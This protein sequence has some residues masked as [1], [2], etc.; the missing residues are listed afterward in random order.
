MRCKFQELYFLTSHKPGVHRTALMEKLAK[1]VPHLGNLFTNHDQYL[2]TVLCRTICFRPWKSQSPSISL[3][4]SLSSKL[5]C[6][7]QNMRCLCGKQHKCTISGVEDQG[8]I[9]TSSESLR[10]RSQVPKRVR[11]E[12]QQALHVRSSPS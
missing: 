5:C 10:L 12:N 7:L 2:D 6:L 1:S 4:V 8:R 9:A 11:I 3:P